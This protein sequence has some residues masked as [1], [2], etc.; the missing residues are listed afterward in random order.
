[1]AGENAGRINY[2]SVPFIS[3]ESWEKALQHSLLLLA[4]NGIYYLRAITEERH[5]SLDPTYV[6]YARAL[7]DKG[8]F[9]GLY[10]LLPILKYDEK[11]FIDEN[12]K[13]K[14]FLFYV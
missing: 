4:L 3:M 11:R 13:M 10:R 5:L 9:R 1:M 12:G 6:K 14:K 2:L 7:N 8:I